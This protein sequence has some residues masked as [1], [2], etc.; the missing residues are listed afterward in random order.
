MRWRARYVG[1][2]GKEHSKRFGRKTDAQA[3]LDKS[4]TEV[5]THTWVD[6]VRSRELFSTMAEAWFATKA[7]KKPKTVAG[8]RSIL[9]TQVLPRWGTTQLAEITYE[10]VQTWISGLSVDGGLRGKG[11]SASRVVQTYQ[12]LNMVLKY[13]IRARRLVVNPAADVELPSVT[14]PEKRYL[15]HQQVYELAVAS[16]RFRTLVLVLAYCGLRFGEAVALRRKSVD[17]KNARILVRASATNVAKRGVVETGTKTHDE[18]KVPIPASVLK[19]LKTELPTD[20]DALVFPGRK[21]G[22]LPLG[23]FRWV[24][25]AAL[26][27]VHAAAAEQRRQEAEESE[28]EPTT[29]EFPLISPHELRHTTASLALSAGANIKVLQ[30]LMGHKTATLT[31]DRYGH[32]MSDD[33]GPIADALDAG[34]LAAAASLR[35]QTPDSGG[36]ALHLV[37]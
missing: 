14:A 26:T 36:P 17:V 18:R 35:P 6:P 22:Y 1:P 16:G 27:A 31:L 28:D 25:D 8:Y 12:V 10:D 33:L 15:T 13:A 23:E 4:T 2:D 11:L 24:F 32:L 9:D 7:T 30:A 20:P 29:P 3:W 37:P 21:G 5:G 34:A 19:L